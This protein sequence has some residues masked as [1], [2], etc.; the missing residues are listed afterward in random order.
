MKEKTEETTFLREG[1][2]L[3]VVDVQNDFI[4]GGAL[5]VPEGNKII[6]LLND[7][8]D[9][10]QT[11]NLH[12]FFTRDWHPQNHCSFIK[13]GG[14]W[15]DHCV[16]ETKG[17]EFAAELKTDAGLP[18]ISKASEPDKDEYSA[19]KGFDSDGTRFDRRLKEEKIKRVFIGGLATDYCVLNTALDAREMGLEVYVLTDAIRAVNVEA[20]DGDKAMET[21]LDKG[22]HF[23]KTSSIG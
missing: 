20:D 8:I 18:I 16:R 6:P 5:P 12:V 10:F 17:A 15:P 21:M 22:A 13:N 4:P 2:A 1:D 11:E 14:A 9:K 7:A 23:L 19:L 3:L